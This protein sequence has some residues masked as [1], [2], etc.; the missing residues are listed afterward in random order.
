MLIAIMTT[1]K[2]AQT[3]AEVLHK[4]RNVHPTAKI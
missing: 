1:L 4:F 2:E 3:L